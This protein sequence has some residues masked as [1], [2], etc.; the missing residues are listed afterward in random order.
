MQEDLIFQFLLKNVNKV[1]EIFPETTME[2]EKCWRGR[3]CIET[4]VKPLFAMSPV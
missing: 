2:M 4:Y 3:V 1:G